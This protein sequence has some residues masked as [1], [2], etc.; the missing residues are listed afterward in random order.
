M[1]LALRQDGVSHQLCE[2]EVLRAMTEALREL[3]GLDHPGA[4]AARYTAANI[5]CEAII[6][7][8]QKAVENERTRRKLFPANP[9]IATLAAS[10]GLAP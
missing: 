10:K 2:D 1:T 8:D 5:P 7:L 6:Y 9:E 3:P 4:R